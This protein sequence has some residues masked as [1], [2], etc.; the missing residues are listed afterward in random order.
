MDEGDHSRLVGIA[1]GCVGGG[2]AEQV[3]VAEQGEDGL[4]LNEPRAELEGV[5]HDQRRA[6]GEARGRERHAARKGGA[7]G[8][9]P[10]TPRR[11]EERREHPGLDHA[12]QVRQQVPGPRACDGLQGEVGQQPRAI[13]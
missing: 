9:R 4:P 7:E 2:M 11:R 5:V 12:R 8:G 1:I 6:R 3:R 13:Q 10:V